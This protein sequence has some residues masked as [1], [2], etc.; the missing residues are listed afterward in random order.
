MIDLVIKALVRGSERCQADRNAADT[1][2]WRG[3]PSM[4]TDLPIP[5]TRCAETD[6]LSIA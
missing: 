6:G 4:S 1:L 2:D 5:E 3:A